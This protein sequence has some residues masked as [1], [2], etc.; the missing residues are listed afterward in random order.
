MCSNS[1]EFKVKCYLDKTQLNDVNVPKYDVDKLD[2]QK[3]CLIKDWHL[4]K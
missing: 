4:L 3:Y 2:Y 1:P